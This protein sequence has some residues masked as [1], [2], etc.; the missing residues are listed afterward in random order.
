LR[1]VRLCRPAGTDKQKCTRRIVGND[2]PG[3]FEERAAPSRWARG[4]DAHRTVRRRLQQALSATLSRCRGCGSPPVQTCC[5]HS[6]TASPDVSGGASAD[7]RI[8][9][10]CRP[11]RR[12][13]QRATWCGGNLR[14][15]ATQPCAARTQGPPRDLGSTASAATRS[16]RC[17]SRRPLARPRQKA[18]RS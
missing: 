12:Q 7:T 16:R 9:T 15:Q 14:R 4:R 13:R 5:R 17:R 2:E 1:A 18:Q 10:P 6:P 8:A 11:V 3:A